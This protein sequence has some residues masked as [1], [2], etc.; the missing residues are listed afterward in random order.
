MKRI[1]LTEF[2][3][4]MLE[5]AQIEFGA[6]VTFEQLL[7]LV[8][9][10]VIYTRKRISKLVNQGLL[11]RIKK[12]VFVISDLSTRGGLSISHYAIV[13]ALVEK[14]YLSFETALQFHGL[15]DQLLANIVA[16]SLTRFKTST[17]DGYAYKF[18]NTGEKY[19]YG[20]DTYIIDGQQVKIA[21]V[22]KALLDL[23][24]F[25]RTLYSVDLVL[26]K[27]NTFKEDIDQQKLIQY[28]LRANLTTRRIM[29]FL[30]DCATFDTEKLHLS[31]QDKS[32]VSY[33]SDSDQNQYNHKWK[34]Y[35][36]QYFEQY[37]PERIDQTTA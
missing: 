12:G 36:D 15:Y 14:S 7:S 20:W 31:I 5:T 26:E 34:L 16:V 32:S 11:M 35:Y 25:H 29:G 33:I 23:L 17:I 28:A 13:N 24:Q 6:I 27:L 3:L 1:S 9:E 19:F 8:D 2:E 37:L 30:M 10:D 22:E 21:D 18:V 4:E